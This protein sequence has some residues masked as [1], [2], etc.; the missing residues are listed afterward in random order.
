MPL[1]HTRPIIY[2]IT[3][4]TTTTETTPQSDEFSQILR[5][6]ESAVELKIPLFQIRERELSGRVLYQLAVRAVDLTRGS[7]TRV[8]VNDRSDIAGAA[9]TNAVQLTAHSL[10]PDVVRQVH[11]ED[12]LIG[13]STHSID[14]ARL[15]RERKADFVLFGPIFDTPSK[16]S[17]GKP[18]GL[19]KL[20]EVTIELGCFPVVAIGGIAIENVAACFEA[21]AAGVAG[22]SLFG[23]SSTLPRI[24]SEI[25]EKYNSFQG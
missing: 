25:G 10:P 24:V 20:R 3:S 17:F 4:G 8:L 14:E 12:F 15:A 9:G 1:I 23:E 18:Q 6:V 5:L 7:V 22:I 13:V 21:G 16:R 2:H 11:G 19:D